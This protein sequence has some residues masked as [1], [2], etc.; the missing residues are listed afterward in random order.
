MSRLMLP[1]EPRFR[2]T[3]PVPV[4]MPVATA[5]V[6][7]PPALTV[8]VPAERADMEIFPKIK[9]PTSVML[10]LL[11]PLVVRATEVPKLLL[12]PPEVRS[13]EPLV[14]LK[15]AAP[16]TVSAALC[17][18]FPPEVTV[19]LPVVTNPGRVVGEFAKLRIRFPRVAGRVGKRVVPA[20]VAALAKLTLLAVE[21]VTAAKVL[22]VL[23]SVML[24]D[25]AARVLSPVTVKP[26]PPW[27]MLALL[28]V[29]VRAP[30]TV[31][32]PKFRS[33]ELVTFKPPLPR[34]SV[35]KRRS[36]K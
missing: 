14:E 5:C 26:A 29:A 12:A 2:V 11:A 7:F 19:R 6:K 23:A 22:P 1:E 28:A 30:A 24:P 20:V 8:S 34:L 25:P 32:V 21:M 36:S 15:E 4:V 31:P 10:M 18:K 13:I 35:S 33:P 16:P 17:V 3:D 9:A 27:V